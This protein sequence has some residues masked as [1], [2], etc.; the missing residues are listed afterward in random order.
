MSFKITSAVID[1]VARKRE[2]EQGTTV[3]F[4]VENSPKGPRANRVRLA[5]NVT[6]AVE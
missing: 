4:E 5:A 3:D 1:P 2:L 6:N